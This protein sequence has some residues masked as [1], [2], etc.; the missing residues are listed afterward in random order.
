MRWSLWSKQ[1]DAIVRLELK[2][3]WL[4]RK[5][6]GVYL[7][8]LA[9]VVLLT[10]RAIF[11]PGRIAGMNIELLNV[12]YAGFF[13]TF[14]LRFSIFFSCMTIFSH[15]IRGE[16]LEKTLHYYLLMPVRREILAFGKYVAG[17][18][19][20]SVLFLFCVIAT[21]L[22]LLLPSRAG[23]NFFSNGAGIPYLARYLGIAMLACMGYGAVFLLVGLFF[24]NPIA[25]A[26]AIAVWEGFNFVLPSVLQ[27]VSVVH[28]LNSLCPVPL[29]KSPFAVLTEAT[30]P[31][32]SIPG[33]LIV[34]AVILSIVTYKIRRAEVTYST[35]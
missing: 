26:L 1:I 24:K 13:Q 9:P 6:L 29:P 25:P 19:A 8:V 33:L 10:L 31:F 27:K 16:I 4:G 23:V 11:R 17:F 5:W 18:V 20:T 30:S 7:I 32:I 15:M 22:L 12:I 35:D 34:T 3:Y 14:L 28:Y 21:N 2:R